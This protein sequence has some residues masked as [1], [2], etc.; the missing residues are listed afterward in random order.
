M[1]TRRGDARDYF[2]QAASWRQSWC[3]NLAIALA[4]RGIFPCVASGS[5]APE[6]SKVTEGMTLYA[7]SADKV[8]A[9]SRRVAGGNVVDTAMRVKLSGA[10]ADGVS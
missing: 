9:V 6:A 3:P 7:S 5:N 4:P 2:A 10:H 1:P 8:L